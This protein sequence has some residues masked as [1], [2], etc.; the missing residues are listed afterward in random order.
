MPKNTKYGFKKISIGI[1]IVILA[2]GATTWYIFTDK[3][4]D[5]ADSKA[6]Y[7]LNASDLLKEFQNNYSLANEKYAEKIILVKGIIS[8]IESADTS[9]NVK[10]TDTASGDY[11]I[12]AFQQ[13]HLAMARKLKKGELVS[14]KGSCSGGV[15]SEILETRYISFKRAAVEKI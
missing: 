7:S 11:I 14:I 4:A 3:F 6:D 15:H 5:T 8:D 2:L 10:M 9:I 1:F 12:F 13:Q